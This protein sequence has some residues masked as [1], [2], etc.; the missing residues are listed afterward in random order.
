MNSTELSNFIKLKIIGQDLLYAV[1]VIN[2]TENTMEL[3]TESEFVQK[4]L[5]SNRK[6]MLVLKMTELVD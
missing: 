4:I 6:F 1:T 2:F 5:E 3:Q